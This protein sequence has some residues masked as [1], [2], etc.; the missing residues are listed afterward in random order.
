MTGGT[1]R[2]EPVAALRLITGLPGVEDRVLDAAWPAFPDGPLVRVR[3]PMAHRAMPPS[4]DFPV[5][6]LPLAARNIY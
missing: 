4:K 3:R 2:T 1:A 6:L 5:D